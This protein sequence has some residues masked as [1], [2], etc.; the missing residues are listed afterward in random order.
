[1]FTLLCASA[2]AQTLP[3]AKPLQSPAKEQETP[4]KRQASTSYTTSIIHDT[5]SKDGKGA[6]S[7]I[8]VNFGSK[9]IQKKPIHPPIKLH[10]PQTSFN[11]SKH[12]IQ[13]QKPNNQAGLQNSQS[14]INPYPT[15]KTILDYTKSEFQI[16]PTVIPQGASTFNHQVT[17]PHPDSSGLL[18]PLLI[19]NQGP[20]LGHDANSIQHFERPQHRQNFHGL[21]EKN[22]QLFNVGYSI[23]IM[24][25]EPKLK[26]RIP[27]PLPPNKVRGDI[28]TGSHKDAVGKPSE[29]NIVESFPV[30]HAPTQIHHQVNMIPAKYI[31]VSKKE[32][33]EKVADSEAKGTYVWKTLSPGVEI[34][35]FLSEEEQSQHF[36]HAGALGKSEGFDITNA[37]DTEPLA[38]NTKPTFKEFKS[39]LPKNTL[40]TDQSIYEN[41]YKNN[42]VFYKQDISLPGHSPPLKLE[43]F[44]SAKPQISDLTIFPQSFDQKL[45]LPK[46]QDQQ[47]LQFTQNNNILHKPEGGF[48]GFPDQQLLQFSQN[49]LHKPEGFSG[50]QDQLLQFPQ[51]KPEHIVLPGPQKYVP[52]YQIHENV[53]EG[54]PKHA[55]RQGRYMGP[56]PGFRHFGQPYRMRS[57]HRDL[58]PQPTS[59]RDL[60]PQ[61]TG[62][63]PPPMIYRIPKYV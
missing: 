53:N 13:P 23:N 63:R 2:L 16:A 51:H 15:P 18:A 46:L 5:D 25:N 33:S 30:I 44:K 57:Y 47:L 31:D 58:H 34:S 24:N 39:T 36:D 8:S 29:L 50:F 17:V 14:Q 35:G 26:M 28:I 56:G 7:S 48:P 40:E 3:E 54:P 19:Q 62:L 6:Q 41:F 12:F 60:F 1:M 52:Q 20:F 21:R 27:Q 4:K 32:S 55:F 45:A 11:P 38:V 43:I 10:K 9:E 49:A 42:P 37:V 59:Y 61:A 22:P